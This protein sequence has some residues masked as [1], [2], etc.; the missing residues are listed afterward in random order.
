M[1]VLW[2]SDS[3][4]TPSGFGNVTRF[5][6]G[7]LAGRGHRVSILGWQTRQHVKWHG[8]ELYPNGS[9]PMGSDAV[10]NYL[11]RHRPDAVI[12]LADVW[13][14][15]YFTDPHVRRQ[16]DLTQTPWVLYF[17]IDG[18]TSDEHLP[19]SWVELLREVDVPI[20]MSRYGQRI[21][22][23]CGIDCEYIPHGVDLEIF[24]PPPDRNLAKARIGAEGKFLVLSDS[25][26]QPR[27]MLPRL[28]DIFARFAEGRPDAVLH[29]HTDP[30][31][32][33]TKSGYYSY[34]VRADIR[35]LGIESQVRFS[36]GFS[37]ERGGGLSLADLAAY[38]QAADVHLLASS[39]EGFGLPTLQAAA[40]GAVP[41]ASAYSASLELVQGHGEAIK[42][43]DW[44]E[45][46]FG[47]RRVLI[48]VEDAAQK[49]VRYYDDREFLRERSARSRDF[50]LGYGWNEVI[51]MWDALLK[52]MTDS[53]RASARTWFRKRERP[54]A[55][56]ERTIPTNMGTSITVKMMPRQA[57][58]LEASIFADT[59]NHGSDVRLPVVPPA[60]EVHG[61]LVPRQQGYICVAQSDVGLF[62]D[63][64]RIFPSLIGWGIPSCLAPQSDQ[65]D[66]LLLP[67]KDAED[68]SYELARSV[69]LLDVSGEIPQA[70]LVNA[71]LYGVL[72]IGAKGVGTQLKLWP[73]LAVDDYDDALNL[74]RALLTNP[75]RAE[76]LSKAARAACER[77]YGPDQKESAACLRRLHQGHLDRFQLAAR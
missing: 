27:K 71:A 72:C 4:D 24:S 41:M 51:D 47:I 25:R 12:A 20:A 15:P 64:R 48:D 7:G 9:D 50:A 60:C 30:N 16:M 26:N 18:D 63:L 32:E 57:G 65:E 40:A 17:P 35:H 62:V 74:A 54:E 38:Y 14:L 5:V 58:K 77:A 36:R 10:F 13:W 33:F 22:R 11:L 67:V 49:L 53:G 28:L 43:E 55:V 23:S 75:A 21:A 19:R 61:V 42:V 1:H 73:E 66:I 45:T 29:L 37:L 68:A 8:C 69:L 70:M 52:S 59:R 46:E 39:G 2:I 3:P 76:R 34:D 56:I 31:D 44:S 6:C